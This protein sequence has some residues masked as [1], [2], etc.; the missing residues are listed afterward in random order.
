MATHVYTLMPEDFDSAESWTRVSKT[1]IADLAEQAS[2]RGQSWQVIECD[3][4]ENRCR[5]ITDEIEE[6]I[7]EARAEARQDP[8]AGC[9]LTVA[10]MI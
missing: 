2:D 3:V 7:S 8:Y 10:E 6:W 1:E 5:D 4:A 9:R